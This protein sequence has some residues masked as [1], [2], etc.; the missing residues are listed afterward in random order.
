[1]LGE[2]HP[3]ALYTA[4]SLALDLYRLGDYQQ[5]RSLD[6]DTLA[7]YRRVLGED[8]PDTL[9][10]ASS[11]AGDLYGLGEYQQARRLDEDTLARSR[12][13]LGE[14]HPRTLNTASNFA[15]RLSALGDYQQ[16]R[17]LYEDTLAR[18]RRCWART[19]PTRGGRPRTSRRCC[20][21]WAKIRSSW[22]WCQ[23]YSLPW[24]VDAKRAADLY[25]EGWTLRQIGAELGVSTTTVSEQLR[26][27]GLTIQ[28]GGPP[29]HPASTQQILEL[30]DQGWPGMRLQKRSV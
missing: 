1:V 13:V 14:D 7:H 30:R 22:P 21:G 29:A 6:E 15:G 9:A 12:R 16:A 8:H 18:Y 28:R 4:N 24:A 23:A 11:L 3:D 19:T 10:T 2:D 25:A 26:R 20:G 17:S 27:V 5:A